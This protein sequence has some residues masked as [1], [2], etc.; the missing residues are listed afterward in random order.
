MIAP[1]K[2]VLFVLDK[3]ILGTILQSCRQRTA[4][5]I[6]TKTL[7]GEKAMSVYENQVQA[8][9]K[10]YDPEMCKI[11]HNDGGDIGSSV[12]PGSDLRAYDWADVLRD[13]RDNGEAYY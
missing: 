1:A 2:K 3:K 5:N 6:R 4:G 7:T 8:T 12:I 11:E 9:E 13:L 10:Y